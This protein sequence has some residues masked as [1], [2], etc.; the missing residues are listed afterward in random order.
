MASELDTEGTSATITGAPKGGMTTAGCLA[1]SAV[2]PSE[3]RD[4]VECHSTEQ[5][6]L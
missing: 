2:I 6:Q 1:T 3:H 4:N 5:D